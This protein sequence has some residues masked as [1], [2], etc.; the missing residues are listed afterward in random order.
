[1]MGTDDPKGATMTDPTTPEGAAHW[2]ERHDYE[3]R[4]EQTDQGLVTDHPFIPHPFEPD[5]C[6]WD[7]VLAP[8]GYSRAEHADPGQEERKELEP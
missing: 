3:Q 5:A 7:E 6:A 4:L 1:M 8:C 2:Q